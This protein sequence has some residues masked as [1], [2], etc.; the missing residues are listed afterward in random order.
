MLKCSLFMPP[1]YVGK[2]DNLSRRC[3]Q[4][5]SG[6]GKGSFHKRYTEYARK[7]GLPYI[8]VSDLLFVCI[9]IKFYNDKTTEENDKITLLMETLLK[10]L[11]SP[12]FSKR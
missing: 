2:T 6:S 7:N 11:A 10:N 4:H 5:V 1:L 3:Y 8:K 12:P 9:P